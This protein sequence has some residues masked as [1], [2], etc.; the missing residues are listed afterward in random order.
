MPRA[1]TTCLRIFA[2]LGVFAGIGG[3]AGTEEEGTNDEGKN[4]KAGHRAVFSERMGELA[5]PKRGLC[6]AHT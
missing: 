6:Q 2:R 3:G 4:G 1:S 5:L